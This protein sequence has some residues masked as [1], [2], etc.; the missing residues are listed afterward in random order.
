MLRIGAP[1]ANAATDCGEDGGAAKHFHGFGVIT[2]FD[3]FDKTGYIIV[4]GAPLDATGVGA[5]EATGSFEHC[6]VKAEAFVDFQIGGDAI[7]GIE[8]R[9]FDS[10][11]GSTPFGG[12]RCTEL[13]A[14]LF[15]TIATFFHTN[16]L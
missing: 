14:P 9:H 16:R 10:G 11:D 3:I 13:Y 7:I 2:A 4:N 12:H 1:E 5:V 8:F 6:L 15:M